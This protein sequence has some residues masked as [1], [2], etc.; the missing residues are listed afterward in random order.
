MNE[1]NLDEKLQELE[2]ELDTIDE[3]NGADP[4]L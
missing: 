4:N 3:E 2:S 1:F